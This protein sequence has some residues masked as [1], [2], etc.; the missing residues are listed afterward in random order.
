MPLAGAI[1]AS[2]RLRGVAV[3]PRGPLSS[4]RMNPAGLTDRQLEIVRLLADGMTNAEIARQVVLSVRTVDG[5]VAA[6]FAKLG[7]SNRRQAAA[8]ARELGITS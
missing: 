5:H 7:A 4:T 3:V 1:R 6:A 2:L 8:R